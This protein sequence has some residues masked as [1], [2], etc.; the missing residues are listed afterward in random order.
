V[1]PPKSKGP[2]PPKGVFVDYEEASAWRF[3]LS[4]SSG[5][6]SGLAIQELVHR[7]RNKS[8]IAPKI[9]SFGKAEQYEIPMVMQQMRGLPNSSV[10]VGSV[11]SR[12]Y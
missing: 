1:C 5:S 3:A 10:L 8:V 7:K 11:R 9:L 2:R 6:Y 4:M 12:T